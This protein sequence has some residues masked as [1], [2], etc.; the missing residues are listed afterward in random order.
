MDFNLENIGLFG[1]FFL[2]FFE[3]IFPPIPSEAVLT[4]AGF[5]TTSGLSFIGAIISSTI[6]SLAGAMALYYL[7][8][9]FSIEKIN[10]SFE[11]GTLKK[12]GFKKKGLGKTLN[13]FNKYR[14]FA[15]LI[16]RC[17]PVVRSL[18]SIPAGMTSMPL[19]KF[20]ILTT[21]GS[22]TWN[23][24]LITLGRIFGENREVVHEVLRTYLEIV[25]VIIAIGIIIFIIYR[26]RTR[27]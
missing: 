10:E 9:R 19:P 23:T 7:G 24:I 21:I 8:K 18:I 11:S 2:I 14:N 6:G 26:K 25:A 22:L 4:L 1:I 16:G 17:V 27:E 12:L 5:L 20:I 15:V 3:T 13:F